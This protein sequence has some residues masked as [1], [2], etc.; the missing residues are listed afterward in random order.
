[1]N[2]LAFSQAKAALEHLKNTFIDPRN[3]AIPSGKLCRLKPGNTKE[4]LESPFDKMNELD[5]S[6][7]NVKLTHRSLDRKT[8]LL[9]RKIFQYC[10]SNRGKM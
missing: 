7:K 10:E 5:C 2:E 4:I 1:M 6:I 9:I 3:T 8:Y